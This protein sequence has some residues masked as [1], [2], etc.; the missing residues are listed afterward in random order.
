[1]A[2]IGIDLDNTILCNNKLLYK[3]AECYVNRKRKGIVFNNGSFIVNKIDINKFNSKKNIQ[4]NIGERHG[5]FVNLQPH[6]HAS[7]VIN[8]LREQGND[9]IIITSRPMMFMGI[10][11][12]KNTIYSLNKN[13]IEYDAIIMGVK[14]KGL[15]C[16]LNN[17]DVLVDNT[18]TQCIKANEYGIKSIWF[19]IENSLNNSSDQSY[20][21]KEWTELPGV[22]DIINEIKEQE[23]TK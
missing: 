19:N 8:E 5:F 1:M 4:K 17:I 3:M 16:S 18:F 2:K 15:C 22:I 6:S 21:I 20:T 9:V 7:E 23:F 10:N 12:A 11:V 13:K 14:D